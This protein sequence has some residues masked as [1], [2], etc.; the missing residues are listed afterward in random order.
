M[1][2]RSGLFKFVVSILL[3]VIVTTQ[4][5]SII[6]S[7]RLYQRLDAIVKKLSSG[8][9][10]SRVSSIPDET[11][12][13]ADLPMPEYPGDEGD[14]LI[15]CLRA[16]PK[17]LNMISV[18][19]DTYT[20]YVVL[21]SIF[22]RLLE[23]DF[24]EAV[25]KPWLAESY[26]ISDN[27][28][29]MVVKLRDDIHF[30]DGVPITADDVIFTF[31]TTMN[32]MV[33]AADLRGYY[34]NFKEVSKI[35]E[36]TV[37]FVFDEMYWKTFEV[38]GLFEVFPKHIYEFEDAAEFN[39]RRSNPVGSGPYVFEKWDVGQQIVLKRNENYWGHKPKLKKI[40]YRIINNDLA[41]LQ[42][43]RAREID[44]LIPTP[45]QFYEFQD[46]KEFQ[47]DFYCLKYWTPGV[48]FYFI[49]W[50]EN[51][52]FFKDRLVRLA[53]TQM[54]DRQRIVELLLKGNAEVVTGPFY[55]YGR[56]SNPDIEPWPYDPEEAKELLKAAG[57]VD[58]DGDGVRDKDGVPFRFKFSYSTGSTFYEQLAKLL[59]DEAAK[60][61]V[62]IL[63]DPYEW[64]VFVERINDKKF[65][66]AVMGFGGT[67]EFDPYQTFHSSQIRDR[68]NNFVSFNDPQADELI[69]KARRTLDKDAR[70]ALY[71]KFHALL[72]EEQ[73]YT[74]LFTRP[75]FR[76]I[77]RR[78]RNVKV[79]KLGLNELE[80]YVPK[81][82]QR[83]H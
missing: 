47:K 56:Q 41:A 1:N 78:F 42:S 28:L 15:W 29:E 53:M 20:N 52:P 23:Y 25:L 80:W 3:L 11:N 45:E 6:Q 17:T 76:F 77:D 58:S 66:A 60:I 27:G 36:R 40:V 50:N 62:D 13:A 18:D 35:D 83:Y 51:T 10:I 26:E 4:V 81:D 57:W 16:E 68:G 69:D 44:H 32:P 7:R 61:G 59:K 55:P 67:I 49:G 46:D 19:S 73:P 82:K 48:P 21:V 38:I 8:Q 75:A 72:H 22:E 71:H 34:K 12:K 54:I 39:N 30:S 64:S 14:W 63:A 74:F 65:E 24:D 5:L 2:G 9:M 37:K 70:Y 33:D 31:E 43:L 79:H